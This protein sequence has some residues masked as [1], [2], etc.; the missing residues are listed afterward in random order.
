[1]GSFFRIH[2]FSFHKL[3]GTGEIEL[4]RWIHMEN[5]FVPFNIVKNDLVVHNLVYLSIT[6]CGE[7]YNRR[8]VKK[9]NISDNM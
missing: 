2:S 4:S 5:M 1:M 6:V 7:L 3:R 9:K 8:K